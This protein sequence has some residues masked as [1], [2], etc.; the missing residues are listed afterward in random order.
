MMF[1]ALVT[2][3]DLTLFPL[4][5]GTDSFMVWACNEPM[6]VPSTFHFLE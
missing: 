2:E 3:I 5:V 6:I 1:T 4:L